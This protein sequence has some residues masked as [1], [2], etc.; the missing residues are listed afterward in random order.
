MKTRLLIASFLI[1]GAQIQTGVVTSKFAALKQGA[2]NLGQSIG[3]KIPV[4]RTRGVYE[5]VLTATYKIKDYAYNDALRGLNKLDGLTQRE[6]ADVTKFMNECQSYKGSDIRKSLEKYR[7]YDLERLDPIEKSLA[8]NKKLRANM[9]YDRIIDSNPKNVS[10]LDLEQ[11]S[12][13]RPLIMQQEALG[14]GMNVLRRC[15]NSSAN[16]EIQNLEKLFTK[17]LEENENNRRLWKYIESKQSLLKAKMI[18]N[19]AKETAA[20]GALPVAFVAVITTPFALAA[21]AYDKYVKGD[22]TQKPATSKKD[23]T[24]SAKK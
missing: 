16:D 5:D 14:M 21:L 20:M 17:A 24:A 15:K 6:L 23:E 10:L 9:K 1:V 13:F 19:S 8:E 12:L 7:S 3:K 22:T 4:L 2:K 11:L 18:F